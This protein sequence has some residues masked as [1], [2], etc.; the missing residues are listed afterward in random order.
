MREIKFRV[1]HKI[2][3]KYIKCYEVG[4]YANTEG[5]IPLNDVFNMQGLIFEQYTGFKDCEGKEIYEGDI[6][7]F[8]NYE[9]FVSNKGNILF[10]QGCFMH[11]SDLHPTPLFQ[12]P[13]PYLKVI[14]NTHEVG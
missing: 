13:I 2:S 12:M 8:V 5:T 11:K 3:K 4:G 14:G 9:N 7:G 1:W 6:V 10:M